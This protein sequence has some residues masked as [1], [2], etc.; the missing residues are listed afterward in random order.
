MQ[1]GAS[2]DELAHSVLDSNLASVVRGSRRLPYKLGRMDG[3][4]MHTFA[5][6][7]RHYRECTYAEYDIT[8]TPDTTRCS[9][10]SY[11]PTVCRYMPNSAPCAYYYTYAQMHIR[12]SAEL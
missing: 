9:Q 8:R 4:L 10:S 7:N 11:T 5:C 3:A 6:R 12:S 2:A 1:E